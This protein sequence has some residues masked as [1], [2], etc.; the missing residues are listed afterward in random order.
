MKSRRVVNQRMARVFF[1]GNINLVYLPTGLL[2]E[3]YVTY[4]DDTTEEG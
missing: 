4:F 1:L 2:F 3:K